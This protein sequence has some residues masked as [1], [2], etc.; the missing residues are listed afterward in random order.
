MSAPLQKIIKAGS[1]KQSVLLR[2][3]NQISNVA[4]LSTANDVAGAVC[5]YHRLGLGST[6]MVSIAL[7]AGTVGSWTEGGWRAIADGWY[8][9]D[10]PDAAVAKSIGVNHVLIDWSAT[11][12]VSPCCMIQL[13]D[14]KDIVNDTPLVY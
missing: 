13:Q 10:L 7:V 5:R 6:G 8:Q 3:Y 4:Q 11:A 12:L 2:V 1:T 14:G 9:L